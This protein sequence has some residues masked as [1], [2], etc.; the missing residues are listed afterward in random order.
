MKPLPIVMTWTVGL[1]LGSLFALVIYRLLTG[2]I[3]TQYLLYGQKKDGTQ[4][5]SPERVQLMI[6]T[7]WIAFSYLLETYETR[8]VEPTAAT[9]HT[10]PDVPIKTLALL[11]ASHTV[12]IAGK[13]YSM[14]IA[15]IAKGV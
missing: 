15:K 11:G 14:L 9:Q 8:V 13:V 7:L 4:Y 2:K 12:Y 1:F 3:N 6:F 5:F 10:L